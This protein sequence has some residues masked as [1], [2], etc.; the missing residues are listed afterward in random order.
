ML[1]RIVVIL[2]IG[3]AVFTLLSVLFFFGKGTSLIAG[4]N[5][6]TQEEQNKYDKK[7]MSIVM[8]SGMAIL[9]VC[10]LLMAIF[11]SKLP[12]YVFYI[13]QGVLLSDCIAIVALLNT[14]CKKK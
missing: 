2:W 7:K 10:Q 13:F 6:A 14:V 8:G 9:A 12:F 11:A 1:D 3:F 4:Y 5:T